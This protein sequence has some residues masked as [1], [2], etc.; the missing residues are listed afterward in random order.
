MKISALHDVLA[1]KLQ[2]CLTSGKVPLWMV[3]ERTVLIQKDPKK[4]IAAS[5]Y[6]PLACLLIMWKALTGIFADK[7]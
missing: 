2:L 4:G 7:M 5:N 1:A 6:R 3:K